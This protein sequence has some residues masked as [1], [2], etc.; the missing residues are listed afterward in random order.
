[1]AHCASVSSRVVRAMGANSA[2]L[3]HQHCKHAL[4]DCR[5][6]KVEVDGSGVVAALGPGPLPAVR[7][8]GLGG[9][10]LAEQLAGAARRR[11]DDQDGS[12]GK[13]ANSTRDSR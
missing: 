6:V 12:D 4:V 7:I 2:H 10:D 5:P 9:A 11:H 13:G 1:L 8:N 3:S